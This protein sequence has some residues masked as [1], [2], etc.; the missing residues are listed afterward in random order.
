M[1]YSFLSEYDKRLLR[2]HKSVKFQPW[3]MT[4]L[5]RIQKVF[6]GRPSAK[7]CIFFLGG[8]VGYADTYGESIAL[9]KRMWENC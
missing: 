3:P 1:Q 8:F 5:L 7:W 2:E 4:K 6:I 9:R